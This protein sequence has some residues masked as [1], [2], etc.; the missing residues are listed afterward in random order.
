MERFIHRQNV[1]HYR[2][3]LGETNDETLRRTLL[4]LIVEEETKEETEAP[5]AA[6]SG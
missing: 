3:L 5:K 4:K 6:K 2:R 1:E